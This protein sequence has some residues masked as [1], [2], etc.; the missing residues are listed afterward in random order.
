MMNCE[1]KGDLKACYTLGLRNVCVIQGVMV[2]CPNTESE[3]FGFQY[4]SFE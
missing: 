4:Y 1:L 3:Q 2:I